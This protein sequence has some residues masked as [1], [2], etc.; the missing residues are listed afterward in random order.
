MN[1][2]LHFGKLHRTLARAKS[3]LVLPFSVRNFNLAY[4]SVFRPLDCS[5]EMISDV[6]LKL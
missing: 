5:R 6:P 4:H 3:L 1:M 2:T